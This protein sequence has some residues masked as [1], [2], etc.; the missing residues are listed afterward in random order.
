MHMTIST[1]TAACTTNRRPRGI[2][3]RLRTIFAVMAQRRRLQELPAER[4]A[5]MGLTPDDV[6]NEAARAPWDV[7][8]NWR[9]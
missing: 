1:G 3:F 8:H 6:R 4:L 5:D 2:L 7:P 9:A